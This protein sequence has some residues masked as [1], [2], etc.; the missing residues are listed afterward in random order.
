LGRKRKLSPNWEGPFPIS[1]VYK[2]GVVEIIY[3]KNKTVKINV[4]RIK[5]YI[6]PIGLQ[7]R[8]VILPQIPIT[9][10]PPNNQNL[11]QQRLPR[12]AVR[13]PP[14]DPLTLPPA[15]PRFQPPI[16]DPSIPFLEM[17]CRI[18][19][20][21]NRPRPLVPF[22]EICT[23]LTFSCLF[24]PCHIFWRAICLHFHCQPSQPS[25]PSHSQLLLLSC[26][27]PLPCRPGEWVNLNRLSLF[28]TSLSHPLPPLHWPHS[29]LRQ[30]HSCCQIT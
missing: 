3:K 19:P 6:E 4:A 24:S 23:T 10:F 15:P 2:N 16:Y 22:L 30:A 7:T 13:P 9:N 11:F 27:L 28:L 29:L 26:P 12:Q 17:S 25:L 1:K 21:S 14:L 5:P 18:S 8:N 20:F